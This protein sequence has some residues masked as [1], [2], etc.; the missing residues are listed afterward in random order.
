MFG[1]CA[2]IASLPSDEICRNTCQNTRLFR[3]RLLTT[4]QD[5]NPMGRVVSREKYCTSA[6][7]LTLHFSGTNIG[8]GIVWADQEVDPL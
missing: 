7:I 5:A 6:D 8:A 3:M 2:L 4:G 1:F